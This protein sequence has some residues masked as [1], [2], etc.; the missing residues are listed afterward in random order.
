MLLYDIPYSKSYSPVEASEELV[1][2]V[3]TEVSELY[4][5]AKLV[6]LDG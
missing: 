1:S 4:G 2:W 3:C 5:K 6:F